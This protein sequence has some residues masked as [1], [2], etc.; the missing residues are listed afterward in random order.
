MEGMEGDEGMEFVHELQ[1]VLHSHC[2]YWLPCR[3]E[4]TAPGT[5]ERAQV[6]GE[7]V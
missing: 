1:S 4:T 6:L 7:Y 2:C 5:E 3:E